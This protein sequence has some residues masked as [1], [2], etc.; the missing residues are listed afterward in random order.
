VAEDTDTPAEMYVDE[1]EIYEWE[2]FFTIFGF[3][4]DEE[5]ADYDDSEFSGEE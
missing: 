5:I 4:P 1:I 2:E 3:Y